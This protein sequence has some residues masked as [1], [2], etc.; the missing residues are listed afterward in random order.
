M[1]AMQYV[2]SFA[3][4]VALA[5]WMVGVYNNLNHLRGVVCSCWSQWCTVT[6]RRNAEL[7][8]FATLLASCVPQESPLPGSLLRLVTDSER[9]LQLVSV[10]RWSSQ[11]GFLG[12][13]EHFLRMAAEQAMRAVEMQAD[14]RVR[15]ACHSV[16]VALYQQDQIAELFNRAAREYNAALCLPAARFLA[17]VFGFSAVDPLDDWKMQNARSS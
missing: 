8:E 6:H 15:Q 12:G 7:K 2:V 9:S 13:A 5:A 10:P 1:P 17:P 11:H 16:S 3:L 4:L 14:S